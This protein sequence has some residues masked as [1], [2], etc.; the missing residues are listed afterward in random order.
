MLNDEFTDEFRSC[1]SESFFDDVR[2]YKD[3]LVIAE[4]IALHEQK[5]TN[6]TCIWFMDYEKYIKLKKLISD[7]RKENFEEFEDKLKDFDEELEE[8]KVKLVL[9]CPL[10]N[11]KPNLKSIVRIF[12]LVI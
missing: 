2:F 1:L 7:H 6:E 12:E 5:P 10:G 8:I 4:S 3:K 9:D 11:L